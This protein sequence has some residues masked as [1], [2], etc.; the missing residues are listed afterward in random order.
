[1]QSS[2]KKSRKFDAVASGD[3]PLMRF[4]ESLLNLF[5]GF[6]LFEGGAEKQVLWIKN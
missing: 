6:F 4:P 1:M 3:G 2:E 5:V